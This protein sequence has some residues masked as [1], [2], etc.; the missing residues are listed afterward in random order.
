MARGVNGSSQRRM[1]KLAV[2]LDR[3]MQRGLLQERTGGKMRCGV[4]ERRC[5]LVDGGVGWCRTRQN[6][7]GELVTFTYGAVSALHADPIEKKPF[8]HFYPGTWAFTFGSWSCN[9]GCPWCQNAEIARVAPPGSLQFIAPERFVEMTENANCQGIALSYNEP[10]LSLEWALDVFRLARRRGLYNAYVTNGYLTAPA[11]KLLAEAGLDALNVDI[12]GDAAAV[13]LYCRGIDVEKVWSTCK[14]ARD[15]G[16]HLEVTTLVIPG[17]NDS[18]AMLVGIAGRIARQ[19]S[20]DVPWHITQYHPAHEFTASPT[21]LV[22]LDKAWHIG[23]EAGLEFVYVGNLPG[24][25]HYNTHCPAC[26][27]LLVQRFGFQV[28][29]NAVRDGRCGQCGRRVPGVW[30]NGAVPPK[31]N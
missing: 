14:L 7:D 24:R 17:V 23:K 28:L 25:N 8:Y 27:A 22:T 11:L 2:P 26:R 4:C 10:T 20:R 13:K 12:K 1:N 30:T 29:L 6:L 21:P 31:Q 16:E 3:L 19:L 18:A 15:L 9:F 5:L